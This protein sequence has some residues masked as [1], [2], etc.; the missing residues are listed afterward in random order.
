[1]IWGLKL[2]VSWRDSSFPFLARSA[3]RSFGPQDMEGLLVD[4]AELQTKA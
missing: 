4:A 1:M 2:G 3:V